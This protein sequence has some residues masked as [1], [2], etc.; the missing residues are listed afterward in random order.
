[1]ITGHTGNSRSRVHRPRQRSSALIDE[2]LS[3]PAMSVDGS[4]TSSARLSLARDTTPQH[5]NTAPAD[6]GAQREMSSPAESMNGHKPVTFEAS[7][8]GVRVVQRVLC[9]VALAHLISDH[10][11]CALVDRSREMD[12]RLER[13]AHK[14]TRRHR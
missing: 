8:R 5:R 6:R 10:R 12:D 11:R 3:R 7:S 4:Q 13:A 14:L 2:I 1:M 9:C